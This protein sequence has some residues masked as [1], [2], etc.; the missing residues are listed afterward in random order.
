MIKTITIMFWTIDTTDMYWKTVTKVKFRNHVKSFFY[1]Q[2][3]E[4]ILKS[5]WNTFYS[6]SEPDFDINQELIL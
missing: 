4:M 2:R 5:D 1:F 3:E 6:L